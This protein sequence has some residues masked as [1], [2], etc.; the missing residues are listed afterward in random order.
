MTSSDDEIIGN[1]DRG[2]NFGV[3]KLQQDIKGLDK[4][5][6]TDFWPKNEKFEKWTFESDA[7][8]GPQFIVEIT[9]LVKEDK[10]LWR[11]HFGRVNQE[12]GQLAVAEI[13]RSTERFPSY[14]KFVSSV[15]I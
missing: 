3:N 9:K 15:K 2:R 7:M 11:L 12:E 14:D 13:I 6:L 8:A 4:F 1:F 5:H 10:T